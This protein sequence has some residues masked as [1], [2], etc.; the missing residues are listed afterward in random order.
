[1]ICTMK[2]KKVASIAFTALCVAVVVSTLTFALIGLPQR[3]LDRF[4]VQLAS[5]E[6]GKT[7]IEAWRARLETAHVK[8]VTLVC[9]GAGCS[10]SWRT[11]NRLLHGLHLAP[12]T[13]VEADVSFKDGVASE[14]YVWTEIE[15]GVGEVPGSGA[16]VHD[17]NDTQSCHRE[18]SAYI[19]QNRGY[20]WAI[21]TMDS[22]VEPSDKAKALAINTACLIRIGGCKSGEA[23]VPEV[24]NRM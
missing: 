6:L 7:E 22:C 2:S 10:T 21:V 12:L 8:N 13:G 19:K 16:T 18:Y 9:K 20:H 14:I 3:N 24:F 23:I 11:D 17:I 5:V 15:D 1:M 4:L